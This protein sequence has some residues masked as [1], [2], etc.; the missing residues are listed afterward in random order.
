MENFVNYSVEQAVRLLA[1]DSP[2]GY[3]KNAADY[4]VNACKELG[5]TAEYTT[6]GGV[7]FCIN[8]EAP[9]ENALLLEAHVDTLGG[10]VTEIFSNGRLHLTNLGGMNPNNAEAENVRIIT[11][12]GKIYTGTFQL[13]NASIH[14]NGDYK[15]ATR[16]FDTMEVVIDEEVSSRADVEKLGIMPGDIV[17]FEP[18]TMVTESGYIKSR[19]LDD[20]L[21]VAILLGLAKAMKEGTVNATRRVWCHV[22]VFEEVGHGGSA[23]VP[24]G[25][26]EAISVDMGCVGNGLGCDERMVSICAKDSG[27]P[28]H[29]EVVSAL[30]DAAKR[31]GADFAVDVYPFYGSDV[32]ATLRAGHDLRHGLIG[33]GVYASHGY[34]RSHKKGVENTLKLLAAYLG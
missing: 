15:T 34:E 10:M 14:V 8:P 25:V 11:R 6:K 17:C 9:V 29:Y 28:Y 22:T 31:G 1:I 7:I 24:A 5:I 32:E 16:S 21:S 30:I 4:V 23:S 3:T 20:K 26:S 27:G 13:K 2:S 33:P 18:R 19:F 12:S